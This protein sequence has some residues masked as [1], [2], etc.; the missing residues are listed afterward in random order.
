MVDDIK[1]FGVLKTPDNNEVFLHFKNWKD[2]QIL[3]SSNQTPIIFE[4]GFQ[5]G[6]NT[7]LNCIYFD[8]VNQ[9][10]WKKV[11]SLSDYSYSIRIN[12]TKK[13][14]LGL[15]LS[16]LD[17]NSYFTFISPFFKNILDNLANDALFNRDELIFNIYNNTTNKYIK[18]N[19]LEL[20]S[21]RVYNLN[22]QEIIKFWKENIVPD[23][24]P[25]QNTLT[26]CHKEVFSSDLKKIENTETRNL[27]ILSKLTHLS[28]DFNLNEFSDFQNT[29]DL[30]DSENLKN[31]VITDLNKIAYTKYLDSKTEEIIKLTQASETNYYVLKNFLIE[32]PKFL[33]ND[34]I[35][36]LTTILKT[37]IVENCSFRTITE[38]WRK[39]FIQEL[40]EAVLDDIKNQNNEDLINILN[41]EK[42]DERFITTILDK[43]LEDKEFSLVLEQVKI[44]APKF[45]DKYDRLVKESA[46]EQQYF[47]F[48][49][50]K[51]ASII[52]FEYI[53]KYLNHQEERYLELKQWLN[54]GIISKDAV[55]ELITKCIFET[56][57]INDRFEFY[58]VF[59]AV[60][61]LID[62][63]SNF[64]EIIEPIENDFVS[65]ILWH[66]KK[67]DIVNFD[68]LKGKF[69]YFKPDDQ[70]YIFKRLFYLK[71]NKLIDFD[72]RKLDEIIRADIDLH[73]A[74][75]K[76]NDFVLDIST[77]IIIECLKSFTETNS[78]VFES[79]LILKD[80]QK[81]SKRKF[82][83][84]KYF[85]LCKGRLT[86]DW[87]WNTEGKYHKYLL[88]RMSFITQ[89]R[90]N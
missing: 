23:F 46:T 84:E 34:F 45:Y 35:E 89:F 86:A 10:H 2:S 47:D 66:F 39:D 40:D 8:S 31:K 85:D 78:F 75:E 69:I 15:V 9:T 42:C 65:L 63:D 68:T 33:S 11:F 41:S 62:I 38:C 87:N 77:H 21:I 83:I 56:A 90:L 19:I 67:K 12:N 4:I 88:T 49:R 29:L 44:F 82:K 51:K 59:Y 80:L 14:V 32:L 17:S 30:I 26:K 5:R 3:R 52:P 74:N 18:S 1:G 24:I 13:N 22:D 6:R 25:E 57:V 53:S 81:N 43:F 37:K 73:L 50:N 76:L 72:L 16:S 48:W 70:V 61:S 27:I 60:K 36:K 71:H 58:R 54:R 28:Q 55:I 64:Q 7:A 20:I 79:D